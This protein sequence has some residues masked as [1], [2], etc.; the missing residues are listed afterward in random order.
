[1]P[2]LPE[3]RRNPPP[4]SA[5]ITLTTHHFTSCHIIAHTPPYSRHFIGRNHA[6][7]GENMPRCGRGR[8]AVEQLFSTVLRRRP[9]ERNRP[10]SARLHGAVWRADAVWRRVRIRIE[11][12]RHEG[13]EN[14]D[15]EARQ[16]R[17]V[18][19]R[20]EISPSFSR[21]CDGRE[22]EDRFPLLPLH[23]Q[24]SERIA[25]DSPDL[26]ER[27]GGMATFASP[28]CTFSASPCLCGESG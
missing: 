12:R 8:K 13:T 3:N 18:S 14:R 7:K 28:P 21:V 19:R 20:R 2:D 23:M 22:D 10:T 6:K 1:M 16:R 26:A 15:S 4:L 25:S 11:P 9:Q 5:W 24:T 27:R 17:P